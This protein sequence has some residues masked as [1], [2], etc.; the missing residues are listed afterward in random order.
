[1]KILTASVL[2]AVLPGGI[3]LSTQYKVDR[4]LRMEI[5]GTLKMETS[6]IEILRDGE[7]QNGAGGMSSETRHKEVHVD[8]VLE[9]K[10]GKPTKVERSFEKV[11]GKTSRTMGDNSSD[12]EIESPLDGVTLEIKR[13]GDKV[14]V[15]AEGKSP[16]AK[17]LEGHLPENFLD[18]LLPEGDVK[19][20][21][22]WD[23]DSDAIKRALRSDVA[24]ALYPPPE[25]EENAGGEGRGGGR[26][27]GGRMGPGPDFL[28][29]AEWKG[30]A[31]LVST[32]KD[33]DGK[34]CAVIE[35]KLEAKGDLPEPKFD[36]G[37]R[38][39]SFEPAIEA[40]TNSF[41][42]AK[43]GFEV[44]LEGKF[45]FAIKERRPVSLD[46]EGTA[47]T[48]MERETKRDDHTMKFHSVV[49]GTVTYKVAVSE[50]AAK[51]EK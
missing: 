42:A 46:L 23:L 22:T 4:T 13:S 43:N 8:K 7:P 32:D 39:R 12:T 45:V 29:L 50:E 38:E 40:P 16:D 49:E 21:A 31:K 36:G 14:E 17:A 41:G 47:R 35:L 28:Q 27:R 44:S 24:K 18:G 1:M 20:D 37:R 10:D 34:T 19:A 6:T 33:V 3:S 2:L 15:T 11:G 5:E 26:R 25:R 51:A 9:V 30:K 48:E